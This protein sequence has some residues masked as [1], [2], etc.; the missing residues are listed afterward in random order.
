MYTNLRNRT[1]LFGAL[2][3]L[4]PLGIQFF[5]VRPLQQSR[6]RAT[7]EM[8]ADI[9]KNSA[10]FSKL[11]ESFQ[12]KNREK[13]R[14]DSST[15][16]RAILDTDNVILFLTQVESI[17]SSHGVAITINFGSE[18]KSKTKG[19][20][21]IPTTIRVRGE[22]ANILS[23]L[24]SLEQ[25]PYYITSASVTLARSN[26]DQLNTN[27]QIELIYNGETTWK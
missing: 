16:P 10:V 2:L 5:A 21:T 23:F 18:F 19:V 11:Q 24:R 25:E 17:G 12:E 22:Y 15:L 3:L 26:V 7:Q 13:Q 14:Y 8:K 6:A 4:I 27:Q 1:I 9:Q 20:Q